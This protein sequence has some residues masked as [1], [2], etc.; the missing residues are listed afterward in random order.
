MEP[1]NSPINYN[2]PEDDNIDIKRY[3]SLFISNWYWFTIALFIA[4]SIAYGINRWSG[5]VYTVSS[6]LL[7]KDDQNSALTDIFPGSNGFRSQQNVNNEIGILKSY[8]LNYRVMQELPEFS[9]VYTS[10]GKRGIAESR[11]YKTSPF[12]VVYDSIEKQTTGQKISIKMLS[13]NKY[14]LEINGG[15]DF[16]KELS[17]GERFNEKGFDFVISLRNSKEYRIDP[18]ASN[19]YYFYFSDPVSMAN[20]YRNKLSVTPI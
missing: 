7:I 8:N 19:R 20:Q 16:K 13:D 17:F 5:K 15:Q 2:L 6:T 1:T 3:L 9:I 11:L 12:I 14:R 18:D 4:L 10:V